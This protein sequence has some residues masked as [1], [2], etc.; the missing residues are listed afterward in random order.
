V[1]INVNEQ[2]RVKGNDLLFIQLKA[3]KRWKERQK[4]KF[5]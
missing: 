3:R 2:G 4:G 5:K 1:K